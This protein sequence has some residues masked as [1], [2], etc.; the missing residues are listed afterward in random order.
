MPLSARTVDI[1]ARG[2]D[3]GVSAANAGLRGGSGRSIAFRAI[4]TGICACPPQ[5]AAGIAVATVQEELATLG[6]LD[7]IFGCFDDRTLALYQKELGA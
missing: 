5:P 7:V 6:D 1:T 3:A 2:A 4:S